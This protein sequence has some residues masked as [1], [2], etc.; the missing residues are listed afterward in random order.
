MRLRLACQTTK[1]RKGK[2]EPA[3]KFALWK[4]D[5]IRYFQMA[6][7]LVPMAGD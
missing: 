5:L 3:V 7:H 2:I 4:F 6:E 1:V